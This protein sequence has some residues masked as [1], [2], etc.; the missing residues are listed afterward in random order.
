MDIKSTFGIQNVLPTNFNKTDFHHYNVHALWLDNG[1]TWRCDHRSV[2]QP[3]PNACK[4]AKLKL[5]P[6][7]TVA[8]VKKIGCVSKHVSISLFMSWVGTWVYDNYLDSQ[9][10]SPRDS[11][12]ASRQ[13]RVRL[14][15]CLAS[16]SKSKYFG[17]TYV[18]RL[19]SFESIL[20]FKGLYLI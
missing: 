15:K 7:V 17:L 19:T 13:S 10:R 14:L 12:L 4:I 9:W 1:T 5:P 2:V 3:K 11:Y 6:R 18:S 8:L 20:F 16:V